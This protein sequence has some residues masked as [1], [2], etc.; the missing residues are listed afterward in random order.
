MIQQ[1]RLGA[2]DGL[3]FM[4]TNAFVLVDQRWHFGYFDLTVQVPLNRKTWLT[5]AGGGA[6]QAGYAYGELG[7]RR[8][9]RGDRGSGSLFVKPSVGA[10]G[11]DNRY[12][13]YGFGPM[14]G[15]HFEWRR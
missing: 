15:C 14:I 5:A 4:L 9:L 13:G 12:D 2:L 1:A 3:N 10:A 8:L 7:L 6:Q 11:I